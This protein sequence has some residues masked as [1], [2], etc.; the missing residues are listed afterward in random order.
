M[1]SIPRLVQYINATKS[2]FRFDSA[3]IEFSSERARL[4][5][6]DRETNDYAF[7]IK[8]YSG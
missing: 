2:L 6:Y 3:E 5:T 8:V 1:F 4:E 7:A